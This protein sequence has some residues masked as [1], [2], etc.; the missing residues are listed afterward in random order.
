MTGGVSGAEVYTAWLLKSFATHEHISSIVLTDHK[1]FIR[2]LTDQG[3]PARYIGM[4]VGEI[5]TK[6]SYLLAILRMPIYVPS[7]LR[8]IRNECK[9]LQTKNVVLES[10]TEK[11]FL[12]GFL[13]LF[14]YRVTWIEHGPFMKTDRWS[15]IKKLYAVSSIFA[16]GIIAVS[17]DTKRDLLRGGVNEKKIHAVVI[18]IPESEIQRKKHSERIGYVGYLGGINTTKGIEDFV[19]IARR[20]AGKYTEL[21]FCA[22]GFGPRISWVKKQSTDPILSSRLAVY[23]NPDDRSILSQIDI[24][25]F[26]THHEEGMS[27]ALLRALGSGALVIARNIGGNRELV[28]NGK[29]GILLPYEASSD[30]FA[31]AVIM[32]KKDPL[33]Q[34]QLR[35][36]AAELVHTRFDEKTQTH[37]IL[38]YIASPI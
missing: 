13:A 29:T 2:Y 30:A 9:K 20:I 23:D 22:I 12:T 10:T 32:L 27:I 11:V 14:G 19:H 28:I 8:Q 35:S 34:A 36:G 6:K 38:E 26:P 15:L 16:R 4:T 5:G 33:L 17:E 31:K 18:G 7:M 24:F 21:K 25:V 3:I 37:K 1:A